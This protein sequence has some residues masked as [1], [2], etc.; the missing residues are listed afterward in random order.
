VIVNRADGAREMRMIRWRFPEFP[1]AAGFS[2][3][4]KLFLKWL[5]PYKRSTSPRVIDYSRRWRTV[6]SSAQPI[7]KRR[8]ESLR[9]V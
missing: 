7:E 9:R 4:A 6:S 3:A 8:P 1:G 2:P 5:Q